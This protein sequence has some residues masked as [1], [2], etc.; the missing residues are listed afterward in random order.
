MVKALFDTNILIDH[1]N[2]VP[3]AR[4]EIDRYEDKA[5]SIVTWMEVLIGAPADVE[6]G[7]RAFLSDFRLIALD[8]TVAEAAVALRR[9]H[10]MKLPDAVILASART[11]DMLL[12]TRNT[13]DFPEEDPGVRVPYRL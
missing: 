5:I 8:D 2:A 13:R 9:A 7:T 11:N 10:R 1:L 12:V 6:A 4:A 3:A